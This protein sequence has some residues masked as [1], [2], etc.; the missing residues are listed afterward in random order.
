[1]K[2]GLVKSELHIEKVFLKNTGWIE[3]KNIDSFVASSTTFCE[4]FFFRFC[5]NEVP[6]LERG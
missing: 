5:Y 2:S 6:L 4:Q 3:V 1:M